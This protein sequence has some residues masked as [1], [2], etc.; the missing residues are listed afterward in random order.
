MALEITPDNM[1]EFALEL[2]KTIHDNDMF[3]DV[4]V[5][6][7]DQM[8]TSNSHVSMD[9]YTAHLENGVQFFV[10]NEPCDAQTHIEYCNPETV[11]LMFEGMLNHNINYGDGYMLTKLDAIAKK[12]GLYAEQGHAWSL[13]FYE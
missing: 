12:Y 10:R 2:I 3:E 7:N 4:H 8:W 6:V 9:E 11:T 1:R 13:S 5:L